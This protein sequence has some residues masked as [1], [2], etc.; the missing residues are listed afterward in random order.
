MVL[1]VVTVGSIYALSSVAI[2]IYRHRT[3]QPVGPM[4]SEE[5]TLNEADE[6]F[7]QLSDVE[8]ELQKHL[9]NFH[10]LL[11]RYDPGQ[12]Q[13]WSY[14]GANWLRRWESLGTRC[15]FNDPRPRPLRKV[16]EEMT[17]AHAELGA[18]YTSYR[19]ELL[20]FGK[21]QTPRLTKLHERLAVVGVR[22]KDMKDAV[23][24]EAQ[25]DEDA[26]D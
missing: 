12:A 18:I 24:H 16:M 9:E 23:T 11:G 26:Q 17:A 2:T 15:R 25:G 20:R 6:C 7:D 21:E 1:S 4:V 13:T 10:H 19:D 14:E 8:V 22:V 5:V 3:Q